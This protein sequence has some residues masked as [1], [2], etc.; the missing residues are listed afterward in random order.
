MANEIRVFV[1]DRGHTLA[2]GTSVREAIRAVMP[3]LLPDAEAGNANITDARG[4]PVN[5][6]DPMPAGAILRATRSSRR[7]GG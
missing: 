3:D 7:A 4:L 1:N 2:A 6:D 5:L